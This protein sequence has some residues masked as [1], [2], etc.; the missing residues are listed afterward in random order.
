MIDQTHDLQLRSW[1]G[2]AN[3][4]ASDFPVQNL[5]LGMFR[6]AGSEER[7]RACVA[8]GDFVLDLG[9]LRVA[10]LLTEIEPWRAA[11]TAHA[12]LN[13]F[14]AAGRPALKALRRGLS[15][16]LREGFSQQDALSGS[17]IAQADAEFTVPAQIG[18]F[19]DFYCSIHHAL[20]V[21]KLFRPDNPLLP[22]YRWLPVGYHGRSSSIRITGGTVRRPAG[23]VIDPGPGAP[24]YGPCRRLDYEAELGFFV[25]AGNALGQ[26]IPIDEIED[27]LFGV[28]LLNDWSA[29]D[30]QPWE[31]Q[32]LGPFLAKSFATTLSPW[33]VTFDALEPY[34]RAHRRPDGDP[35]PL[36][37]LSS[38]TDST[39][40]AIDIKVDVYMQSARMAAAGVAPFRLSSSTYADSY[41]TL[42]QVVAHHA[43][44]G[45][46]LQPG[47]L[48][49]SGTL[50]GPGVQS[51]ACLLELTEG[52][53]SPV[54]LP[55][56][57][58]RS[59]LEDG[60]TL[61]LRGYCEAEGFAR[62]GLGACQAT[63]LG[64]VPTRLDPDHA[65]HSPGEAAS[66]A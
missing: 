20:R 18:D 65:R 55:T 17:L 22:N 33:I 32:P 60:D 56:G 28:C 5:P 59:F 54:V 19:S 44:N 46:N 16:V 48:L 24:A 52:G 39:R 42:A 63:V 7:F 38:S 64:S 26:P 58:T 43:S 57:E 13:A 23:Q 30:I 29:R 40:G 47:D 11:L 15:R 2:S 66:V 9:D 4:A 14:M 37:H 25:G 31:Y 34:R 10:S 8:I 6:R 36:P 41:W 62:I 51:C 21:G 12:S 27:H 50:S 45:C 61:I 3:D 53:R 1:V 35:A 49:G